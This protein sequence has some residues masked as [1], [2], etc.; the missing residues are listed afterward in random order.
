VGT[1]VNYQTSEAVTQGSDHFNF[2]NVHIPAVHF[3]TGFHEDYHCQ[4]DHVEK[5]AYPNMEKIGRFG[6]K[7]L[8][9]VANLEKRMPFKAASAAYKRRLG[10]DPRELTEDE[11]ADE[12]LEKNAGGIRVKSVS[13]G[14]VAETAGIEQDDIIVEFDGKKL[15]LQDSLTVLRDALNEVKDNVDVPIV[16]IRE[17]KRVKV[18]AKWE[19]K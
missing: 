9:S 17:G 8:V 16:V 3:F 14:S 18:T 10:I 15:P 1:D 11:A 13:D 2:A 19:K 5:I 12:K 7:L 6:L 4:S